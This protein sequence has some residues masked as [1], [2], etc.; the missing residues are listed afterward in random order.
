MLRIHLK[1]SASASLLAANVA[2]SGFLANVSCSFS[3]VDQVGSGETS[4]YMSVNIRIR[5]AQSY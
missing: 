2:C 1:K 5:R 4:V 3:P